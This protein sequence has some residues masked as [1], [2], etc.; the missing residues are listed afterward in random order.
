MNSNEIQKPRIALMTYSI[1][2][3]MAKGTAIVARKSVDEIIKHKDE[4]DITFIHFDKTEDP[5]YTH[6]IREVIFPRFK[7]NVL[8]RRFFRM[9]YY[10]LSTKDRYDVVHWFQARL[11]PFFWLAPAKYIIASLHGA[12][13]WDKNAPFDMMRHV[14]NWSARL[15]NK[16]I[17]YALA[18]SEYAKND[19][20]KYYK[21]APERVVVIHNGA[22]AMYYPRPAEEIVAVKKK[23]NLPERFV[24]NVARLNHNKNAFTVIRAFVK[25]LKDSGDMETQFVNIGAKGVEEVAVKEFI[26][27]SGYK[28]RITL[29]GYVEIEDLAAFYCSSQGLVFPLLFEGFGLPI[30]EAMKCGTPAVISETSFPEITNNESILVNPYSE[31]DIA[32][33]IKEL[34]TNTARKESMIKNG[35]ALSAKFTWEELGRQTMDLY[36]GLMK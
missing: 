26:E 28:D 11:Y 2:G 14:F 10:F 8:N 29:V 16:K 36:K 25:Y 12:G 35:L 17:R 4:F 21:I 6:G 5:I 15:C 30:I 27:Q 19:I 20:V 23:Y 22:E 13:D 18:G 33:A 9:M 31:E 3:R 7:W 34:L 1:D 32:H 24:M